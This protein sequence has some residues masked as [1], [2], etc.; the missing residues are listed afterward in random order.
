M[1][2]A[3]PSVAQVGRSAVVIAPSVTHSLVVHWQA[4]GSKRWHAERV[5][6][7]NSYR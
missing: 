1:T 5:A 6:G 2:A 4:I 7:K 3:A